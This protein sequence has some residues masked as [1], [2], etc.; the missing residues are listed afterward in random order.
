MVVC[1]KTT[2]SPPVHSCGTAGNASSRHRALLSQR[3]HLS[4]LPGGVAIPHA[5]LRASNKHS[6]C[7][8]DVCKGRHAVIHSVEG[9]VLRVSIVA[10]HVALSG[11]IA[12][13]RDTN[14]IQKRSVRSWNVFARA[15]TGL[16]RIPE[17]SFRVANL[18]LTTAEDYRIESSP[19]KVR[20]HTCY[21][22]RRVSCFVWDSTRQGPTC[23]CLSLVPPWSTGWRFETS[24]Y[25]SELPCNVSQ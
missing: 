20:K 9:A 5:A 14:C 18:I 22:A 12:G 17:V 19:P 13:E 2:K 16:T 24:L 3:Y 6:R 10:G 4:R 25:A 23:V 15:I 21:C 11:R 7:S 8:C 1:V